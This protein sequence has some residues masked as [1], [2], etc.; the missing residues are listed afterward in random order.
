[1][2]KA[3]I[4][5]FIV[6]ILAGLSLMTLGKFCFDNG[7]VAIVEIGGQ[8][9]MEV[10]L[11][12]EQTIDLAKYGIENKL[13]VKDSSICVT[14]SDCPNQICVSHKPISKK[15]EVICCLPHKLVIYMKNG[16]DEL[17]EITY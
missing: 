12:K 6:F 15:N 4:L 2:K 10:S 16:R 17:D 13:L 7:D 3:D 8:E 9:I 5:I 1:M 11:N 14:Y